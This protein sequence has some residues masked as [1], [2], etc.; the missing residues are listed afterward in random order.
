MIESSRLK[1]KMSINFKRDFN[2]LIFR[3]SQK[4]RFVK[5]LVIEQKT[6]LKFKKER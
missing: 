5:N 1:P 2:N 3:C 4:E 6:G